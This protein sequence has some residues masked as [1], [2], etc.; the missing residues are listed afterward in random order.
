VEN[1]LQ[2]RV[3]D[4]L[5]GLPLVSVMAVH[6]QWSQAGPNKV[7]EG[8]RDFLL[9]VGEE[10]PE[11]FSDQKTSI[12]AAKLVLSRMGVF[13]DVRAQ[14]HAE[15]KNGNEKE[16]LSLLDQRLNLDLDGIPPQFWGGFLIP[17]LGA[18]Q[19]QAEIR[20]LSEAEY[21]SEHLPRGGDQGVHAFLEQ[22][23]VIQ[24]GAL[25]RNGKLLLRRAAL[26]GYTQLAYSYL[27]HLL[28]LQ[29]LIA[30][31]SIA[32]LGK[33]I[34]RM[35][36]ENAQA[37]NKLISNIVGRLVERAVDEH[38]RT[39]L[40][41]GS[42][43]GYF[44]LAMAQQDVRVVGL[45]I[46]SA[47]IGSSRAL[48]KSSGVDGSLYL[49]NLMDGEDLSR[50]ASE[51][52]PDAAFINYI[53]HDIAG[54]APSR[55][56]GLEI[57][58]AFLDMYRRYFPSAPLYISESYYASPQTLKADG[59]A[60]AMVFAF[61]HA[62]SPQNLLRREELLALLESAGFTVA[63]DLVHTTHKDRSPANSTVMAIP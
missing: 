29:K 51:N 25:A 34:D 13:L 14:L 12:P 55:E 7:A 61:L 36:P 2:L 1:A 57:V 38:V 27:P 44:L 50:I 6:D 9:V 47:A 32:G 11:I 19:T 8:I 31:P 45:D 40:D 16:L 53:L 33:P 46:S 28:N 22:T 58:K 54:S 41:F 21:L 62:I 49:G 10:F 63:D 5:L 24:D 23:G 20:G 15:K 56:Q 59:N 17:L 30:D 26:G 3:T 43:G 4:Y 42:G 60:A 52:P 39:V 37:S 35:Q 48:F 18:I